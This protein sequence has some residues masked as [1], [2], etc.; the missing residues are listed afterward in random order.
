MKKIL[1][2]LIGLC[3]LLM[4]MSLISAI[5]NTGTIT[6]TNE[7]TTTGLSISDNEYFLYNVFLRDGY[8][9]IVNDNY[10]DFFV[11]KTNYK[12]DVNDLFEVALDYVNHT[13]QF[14]LVNDLFDYT[15]ENKIDDSYFN[16]V[17]GD[18]QSTTFN[19]VKFGYYLILEKNISIGPVATVFVSEL[20]KDINIFIKSSKPTLEKEVYNSFLE[21]Y[22]SYNSANIGDDV[23]YKLSTSV[24]DVSNYDEYLFIVNDILSNGLTFNNDVIVYINEDIYFPTSILS[25]S[26]YTVNKYSDQFFSIEFDILAAL[27][28]KVISVGDEISIMYSA[29]LNESALVG[30]VGNVNTAYLQYSNNPFTDTISTTPEV[31]TTTF[32]FE[33]NILKVSTNSEPLAGVQFKLLIDNDIAFFEVDTNLDGTNVYTLSD[34][35]ST[36]VLVTGVN[37]QLKVLGLS[38]LYNY[39]LI[40]ITPLDGYLNIDDLYFDLVV[41][42]QDN[43]VIYVGTSVEGM[44][45][46][47][48][49]LSLDLTIINYKEIDLPSTG[50]YGVS[51]FIIIGSC[52]V[53]FSIIYLIFSIV[54]KRKKDFE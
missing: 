21:D 8:E 48:S 2:T 25:D 43:D 37:G 36:S 32:T 14:E 1:I 16:S 7:P 33:L 34:K 39:S 26:Y 5:E 30:D 27:N 45:Q 13:D 22:D 11:D 46:I 52:V 12:D 19:D 23:L 44:D 31:T 9:Y 24:F 15:I 18:C 38:E 4:N 49:N 3:L 17:L 10:V 54:K 53:S 28:D 41:K 42:Y 29:K 35:G 47:N 51:N 40:E 6:I 20:D 50:G